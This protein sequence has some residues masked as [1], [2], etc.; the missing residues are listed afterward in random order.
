MPK[1]FAFLLAVTLAGCVTATPVQSLNPSAERDKMIKESLSGSLKDPYSAVFGQIK[2]GMA[3][4]GVIRVCG[5]VNAKNSFG[6]YVGM[7]PYIGTIN[8]GK[9]N[10]QAMA[11]SGNEAAFINGQCNSIGLA[12]EQ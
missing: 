9:F 5:T 7:M 12:I 1:F 11:S 6:G 3:S 8:G 2:T 10:L 4:N